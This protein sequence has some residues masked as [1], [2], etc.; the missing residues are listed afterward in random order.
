MYENGTWPLPLVVALEL[1]CGLAPE[2]RITT[3]TPTANEPS[4]RRKVA[5][6]ACDVPPGF[7]AAG[8]FTV[9]DGFAPVQVFVA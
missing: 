3:G 5:V 2:M 7:V 6:S 8:G 9:H 4:P 1:I